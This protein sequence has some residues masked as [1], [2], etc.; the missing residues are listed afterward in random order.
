MD[1]LNI[2]ADP[3]EPVET[4]ALRIAER[5]RGGRPVDYDDEFHIPLLISLFCRG[6]DVAAYCAGAEIC[7]KTFYNWIN[8]YPK[9]SESYDMAKD[10]AR[11][12]WE[13]MA[14]MNMDNPNFNT[15]LWSMKMRNRFD[16]TEHR[17]LSIPEIKTAKNVQEQIKYVFNELSNGN[18]TGSEAN[19]L[20]SLIK[21]AIEVDMHTEVKKDIKGIQDRLGMAA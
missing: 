13:K 15:K 9:F 17:K 14:D 18:L 16:Y 8:T 21:T 10:M 11:L 6:E 12:Y 1:D 5:I 7:R 19:Q 2:Y 3:S 20:G 4:K